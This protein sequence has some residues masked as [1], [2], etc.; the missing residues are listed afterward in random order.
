MYECIHSN[1]CVYIY[2]IP[3]IPREEFSPARMTQ[4]SEIVSLFK[5]L[6]K[7]RTGLY[8]RP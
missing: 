1:M 3:V 4:I 6:F 8:N 7:N 5:G 2:K